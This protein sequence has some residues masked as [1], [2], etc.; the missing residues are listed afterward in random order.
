MT[1]ATAET[2]DPAERRTR[3][4]RAASRGA[5]AVALVL[6]AFATLGG[7]ITETQGALITGTLLLP[8]LFGA[9]FA[10]VLGWGRPLPEKARIYLAVGLVF[11]VWSGAEVLAAAGRS[12]ARPPDL[13]PPGYAFRPVTRL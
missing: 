4:L 11:A 8:L 5:F 9:M 13:A 3:R 6:P 12:D 1:N 7:A 2:G 10:N